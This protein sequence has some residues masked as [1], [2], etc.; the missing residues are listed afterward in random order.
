MAA[1]SN[2]DDGA[3]VKGILP[4]IPTNLPG[5]SPA[6]RRPRKFRPDSRKRFRHPILRLYLRQTYWISW[7]ENCRMGDPEPSTEPDSRTNHKDDDGHPHDDHV[8]NVSSDL[9]GRNAVEIRRRMSRARRRRPRSQLPTA[10]RSIAHP[11]FR[12]I[13]A[14]VIVASAQAPAVFVEFRQP[15]NPKWHRQRRPMLRMAVSWIVG[16]RPS[17]FDAYCTVR[18]TYEDWYF[19]CACGE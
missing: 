12:W 13:I 17:W 11:Y 1:R 18:S 7:G 15:G 6:C 9:V 3:A 10:R 8:G 4:S 19:D 2:C 16:I 5:P 14:S